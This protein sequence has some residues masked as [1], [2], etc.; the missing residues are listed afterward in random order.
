MKKSL[1]ISTIIHAILIAFVAFAT[2][3]SPVKPK[4]KPIPITLAALPPKKEEAKPRPKEPEPLKKEVIKPQPQPQPVIPKPIIPP[5]PVVQQP[6][7][8]PIP[9]Q[10]PLPPKPVVT[11]QPVIKAPPPPPAP[12][13]PS[14][15]QVREAK[16]EYL[17]YIRQSVEDKKFYPKVAKKMGQTG[18]PEVTFTVHSDGSITHV[19]IKESSGF[20]LLDKA[21][22]EI[23]SAIG[24]FKPIPKELDK[25]SWEITIPIEYLIH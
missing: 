4:P 9:V 18:T 6:V 19:K 25:E 23:F 10:P 20:D 11:E 2:F 21:A 16:N 1:L 17:G 8:N 14:Q 5:M 22:I 7:A 15:A 13:R 12:P 3:L 24:K